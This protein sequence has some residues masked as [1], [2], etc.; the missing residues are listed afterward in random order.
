[1]YIFLVKLAYVNI[2]N[3]LDVKELEMKTHKCVLVG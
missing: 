3:E 1:M 2:P